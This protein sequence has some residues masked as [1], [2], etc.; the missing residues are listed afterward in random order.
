MIILVKKKE[1]G[2]NKLRAFLSKIFKNSDKNISNWTIFAAACILLP[3]FI[4]VILIS[5]D[6]TKAAMLT[7]MI[8]VLPELLKDMLLKDNY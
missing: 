7:R 8:H 6:T 2:Q 1:L 5:F 4:Y 3:Q